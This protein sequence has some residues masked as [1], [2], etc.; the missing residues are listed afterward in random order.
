MKLTSGLKIEMSKRKLT[1]DEI[2]AFIDGFTVSDVRIRSV[3]L[4]DRVFIASFLFV[5][6]Y[7]V[8]NIAGHSLFPNHMNVS[9]EIYRIKEEYSR[10]LDARSLIGLILLCL[11]NMSFFFTNHFRFISTVGLA[12]LTNATVDVVSIF[13]AYISLD[14]VSPASVFYW[15]RPVSLIAILA[16]ILRFNPDR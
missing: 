14:T 9:P 6:L 11:F 3:F 16:C 1:D 10:L 2:S 12:Y 5:N 8:F 4:Q 15:L 13:G 7:V